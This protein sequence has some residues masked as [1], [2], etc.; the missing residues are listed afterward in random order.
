MM[1][2][3]LS[4]AAAVLKKLIGSPKS[5]N[6][7]PLSRPYRTPCLSPPHSGLNTV[8]TARIFYKLM[9]RLGF[10]KFYIQGG[11]W[12]SLICTNMAQLVPK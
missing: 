5:S 2:A 11:D 4:V 10:Q 8:A 3:I 9:S 7:R 1:F 6:R 12:G